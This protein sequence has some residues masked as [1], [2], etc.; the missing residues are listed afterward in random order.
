[1]NVLQRI[2]QA[3]HEQRYR[4]S[5]HANEEMADDFL[6]AVDIENIIL[7]GEIVR[8]FINDPRSTRYEVLG[9][10]VDHRRAYVVCRFLSSGILLVITAYVEEKK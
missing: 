2:R 10:T 3:I 8:K 4:I 9:E 7:T 1:M 5:S 6:M